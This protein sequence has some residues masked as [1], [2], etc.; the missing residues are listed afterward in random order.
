MMLRIVLL[1]VLL[2]VLSGCSNPVPPEK[3]D[4]V[5]KWRSKEM[6][7]LILSDGTID[8]QRYKNG[9]AV[10]V[11]G[12]LQAFDGDDFSVGI[13]FLSTTFEVSQPPTMV[14][15]RWQMVVDGVRL[16]RADAVE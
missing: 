1:T 8:Y 12:P 3:S 10:T 16:T 4:Y 2:T 6:T 11:N 9:G 15:G 13:G 7:L 14:E 5:G